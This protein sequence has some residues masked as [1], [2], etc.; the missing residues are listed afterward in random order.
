MVSDAIGFGILLTLIKKFPSA[1]LHEMVCKLLSGEI[2][3]QF[4][5]LRH[6]MEAS[7]SVPIPLAHD[8]AVG[9]NKTMERWFP[10]PFSPFNRAVERIL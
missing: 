10:C 2:F 4:L 1:E 3:L 6:H 9:E 7:A 8:G 5:K